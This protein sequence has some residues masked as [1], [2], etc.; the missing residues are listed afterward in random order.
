MD[1]RMEPY[2]YLVARYAWVFGAIGEGRPARRYF[3]ASE[4]HEKIEL[5]RVARCGSIYAFAGA[6]DA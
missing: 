2:S 4:D 1:R 3:S 5:F 6:L